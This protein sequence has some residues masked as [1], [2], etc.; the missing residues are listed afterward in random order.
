LQRLVED[1]S[2]TANGLLQ[3]LDMFAGG[4]FNRASIF[5]L[6]IMPYISASIVFQLLGL[7]IPAIQKMQKEGESSRRKL[8]QWVRLATIVITLFQASAYVT[9]LTTSYGGAVSQGINTS[10]FWLT[11]T[12]VLTSGTIFVMWLGEKITDK[13]IGNGISLLIMVGI[14][15]RLPQSF[16]TELDTKGIIGDGVI[17]QPLMVLIELVFFAAIV[18][19]SIALLQAVRRIPVTYARK[20]AGR[21]TMIPGAR[22]YIPL[23]LNGSGVM[24]IIFAQALMFVPA[25]LG[26]FGSDI[27]SLDGIVA[28]L[29]DPTG[30]AYNAVLFVMVI[31]FTYFYTAILFN[32]QQMSE[33]LKKNSAFVPGIKP[34][35]ETSEHIDTIM[36]R[37]TLPGAILLGIITILP[38][39]AA[40]PSLLGVQRE[41]SMFFGGTSLLI[42]VG[43]VLDTLQQIDSYLLMQHYDGLT[44]GK[45]RG[46]NE[47]SPVSTTTA[48]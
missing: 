35:A 3:Y 22:Q 39:F 1:N 32:P 5:A 4:A 38:A 21:E 26:Q 46:R 25:M 13:G 19:V 48:I 7:T 34:G 2:G 36:S 30:V 40:H 44:D 9:Y 43:V 18:L 8:N 28:S 41:F 15:A 20:V 12:V 33:D 17:A 45:M 37:I 6:G 24:P 14:I 47:A 23:K 10:L 11:T 27:E 42:L 16:L 29:M 31:A